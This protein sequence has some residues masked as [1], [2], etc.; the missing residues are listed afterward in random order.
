VNAHA[1][2]VR[3][4]GYEV[5]REIE[6]FLVHEADLLDDRRFEEWNALFLPEALYWVPAKPGQED[7]YTHISIFCDDAEGRDVRIRRLRHQRNLVEEV[8][9]RTIHFV[10]N[11][12][13]GA[14]GA[15]EFDVRSRLQMMELR[16][17]VQRLYGARV[18]HTLRRV[19][20]Q[21]RIAFKRVDLLNSDGTLP[22]MSVPF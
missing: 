19:D 5:E 4:A 7:P 21:L 12:T 13:I 16:A 17:D 14:S 2:P 18:R 11:V 6:A 8:P 10:Q 20:G 3:Q 22:I 15:E 9:L 1:A